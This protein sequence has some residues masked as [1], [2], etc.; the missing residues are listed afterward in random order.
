MAAGERA[1]AL[2][3]VSPSC[4]SLL[5]PKSLYVLLFPL[6]SCA[7]PPL[8]F[9]SLR[10]PPGAL[11]RLNTCLGS[12]DEKLSLGE[13]NKPIREKGKSN[14][15][16]THRVAPHRKPCQHSSSGNVRKK[17]KIRKTDNPREGW[18]DGTPPPHRVDRESGIGC[19]DLEPGRGR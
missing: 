11:A 12:H 6:L 19:G 17:K 16:E 1:G 7:P 14:L 18:E 8:P 15:R 3:C 9:C 4:A 10:V 2:Q 13:N 5:S